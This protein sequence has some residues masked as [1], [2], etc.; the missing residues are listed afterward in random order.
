[1]ERPMSHPQELAAAQQQ[2]RDLQAR[3]QEL[4]RILDSL[5]LHLFWKDQDSIYRGCNQ[6]F[7][8]VAGFSSIDEV[9]GKSDYGLHWTNEEADLFRQFD[10][11]VMQAD[12]AQ[13]RVV[14]T[15][16]EINEQQGWVATSKIPL[17]DETGAVI[18]I[19]GLF[20]DI[21]EQ[22]KE[23]EALRRSEAELRRQA[24]QLRQTIGELQQAQTK[25]VQAEKMS[26]LGQ[27]VAGIAHEINNPVS[28][29]HGNLCFARQHT[30]DLLALIARYQQHYPQPHPEL[31]AQI[32]E[33]ELEFLQTDLPQLFQSMQ[34]GA[35]RICQIV[36]SLRSFSRLDEAE[37][38]PVDLHDGIDSTLMILQNRLR[39]GK[40]N[41]PIQVV[42]D[43]GVLP[44]VECYAGPLNQVFMNLLSNAIDAVEERLEQQPD[45]CPQILIQ[46]RQ[47]DQQVEISIIDS[48]AGM[49]PAIANQIFDPFFTTKA[50]GQGTGLGLSISYQIITERHGG[51]LSCTSE[52]GQGTEFKVEIPV[53]HSLMALDHSAGCSK[54]L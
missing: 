24:Q 25:L 49:S 52:L 47:V 44:L 38:K 16:S 40:A 22:A 4:Q 8:E 5:P 41:I 12:V 42:K 1:M 46:T 9:L 45:I 26:S 35:E 50:P 34:V 53:R 30:D 17:H 21:T 32:D 19:L 43:Y 7:A 54:A 15:P 39:G 48:G 23:E 31:Q 13:L 33:I 37:I 2:I 36:L 28:F 3:N 6:P 20:E 10:Q 27:L 29:I 51:K 18:G 11:Q 14:E